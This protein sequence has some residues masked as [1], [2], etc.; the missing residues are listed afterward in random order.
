[1][2]WKENM[3]ELQK[4]KMGI[5]PKNMFFRGYLISIWVLNLFL[6]IDWNK[7]RSKSLFWKEAP[8]VCPAL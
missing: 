4:E 6:Q 8:H 3:A 7:A 1:M 2:Q 5:N